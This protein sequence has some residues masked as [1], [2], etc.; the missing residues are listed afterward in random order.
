MGKLT[1]IWAERYDRDLEDV[2]ALQDE[3]TGDC[4]NDTGRIE[5]DN[6]VRARRI[7]TESMPA[8]ECVLAAKVLAS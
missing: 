1:G 3:I 5:S 4:S 8:Y 6:A 7:P 2:F